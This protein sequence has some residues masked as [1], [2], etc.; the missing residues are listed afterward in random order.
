VTEEN[1]AVALGERIRKERVLLGLSQG[2]LAEAMGV[3]LGTM[4]NWERGD[5][6]ISKYN[7][8]RLS[9][10]FRRRREFLKLPEGSG[11]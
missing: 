2:E 5:V 4:G 6:S 11:L 1:Y 3:A 10:F 7:H 8:G 9:A